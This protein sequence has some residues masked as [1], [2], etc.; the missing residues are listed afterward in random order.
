MKYWN[1][2]AQMSQYARLVQCTVC[3]FMV[4]RV[5]HAFSPFYFI[6]SK[7]EKRVRWD[8]TRR[9][10]SNGR[11]VLQIV[12]GFVYGEYTFDRNQ[13]SPPLADSVEENSQKSNSIRI[14]HI[15]I[16]YIHYNIDVIA[17]CA[18]SIYPRKMYALLFAFLSHY[19]RR[20][21]WVPAEKIC[22]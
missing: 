17:M 6:W 4:N 2:I 15:F 22:F 14:T 1:K 20:G 5:W 12:S 7:R 3:A 8:T 16:R 11:H 13:F 21:H 18:T 19:S 9:E 10:T